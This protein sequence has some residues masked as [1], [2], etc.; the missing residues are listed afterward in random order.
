MIGGLHPPAE[1]MTRHVVDP[2]V[3][4]QTIDLMGRTAALRAVH[5]ADPDGAGGD[6]ALPR[7]VPH[8]DPVVATTASGRTL[9][10]QVVMAADGSG[11]HGTV[12]LRTGFFDAESMPE[13][14]DRSG[15]P[16]WDYGGHRVAF[17][18]AFALPGSAFDGIAPFSFDLSLDDPRHFRR[19]GHL[20]LADED[21]ASLL[22]EARG[23]FDAFLR[24]TP[25]LQRDAVEASG[26]L[27]IGILRRQAD[28][29]AAHADG[30]RR[31][32]DELEATLS[33]R[34]AGPRA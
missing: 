31:E 15:C 11:L 33:A 32:A 14:L 5:E 28:L 24:S 26:L 17:Q 2:D 27:R 23:V 7:I 4:A 16:S 25:N 12:Y 6:R 19:H 8:L 30:I 34:P 10:L 21:V 29:V 20:R 1:P 18:I 13:G 9:S 3:P 22:E